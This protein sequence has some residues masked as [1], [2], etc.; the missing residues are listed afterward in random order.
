MGRTARLTLLTAAL[1][2]GA[3]ALGANPGGSGD[4]AP[5]MSA[6]DY[7]PAAEYRAGIAALLYAKR[8]RKNER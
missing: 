6:P 4:S 3:T 5:S 7:D 2:A 8:S 1:L